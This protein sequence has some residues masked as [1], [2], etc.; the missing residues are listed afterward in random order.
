[1]TSLD[2][3]QTEQLDL[4]LDQIINMTICLIN[5]FSRL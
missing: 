3:I 4:H 5:Q 2:N 1:M